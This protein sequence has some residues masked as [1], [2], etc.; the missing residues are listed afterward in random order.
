MAVKIAYDELTYDYLEEEV[1]YNGWDFLG[2][3]FFSIMDWTLKVGY[4]LY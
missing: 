1:L 4:V 3:F 2:K